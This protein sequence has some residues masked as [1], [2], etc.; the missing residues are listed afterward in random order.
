MNNQAASGTTPKLQEWADFFSVLNGNKNPGKPLLKEAQS[1][2][3]IISN[4]EKELSKM[5][6]QPTIFRRLGRHRQ[7]ALHFS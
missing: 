7:L 5:Q 3:R 4:L 6:Q 1:P 2:A